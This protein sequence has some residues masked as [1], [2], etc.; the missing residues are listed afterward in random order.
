MD[1]LYG[2]DIVIFDVL[3]G[4]APVKFLQ[5]VKLLKKENNKLLLLFYNI[6]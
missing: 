4:T 3:L 1:V 5:S 2:F 6:Y